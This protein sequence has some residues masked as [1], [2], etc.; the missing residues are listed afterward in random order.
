M[1]SGIITRCG[2][3][4]LFRCVPL[5]LVLS[6]GLHGT[7]SKIIGNDVAEDVDQ[8]FLHPIN[9]F[10]WNEADLEIVD[11]DFVDNNLDYLGSYDDS[12]EERTKKEAQTPVCI[13]SRCLDLYT[14]RS[15]PVVHQQSPMSVT[16][17]NVQ[18]QMQPQSQADPRFSANAM[19]QRSQSGYRNPGIEELHPKPAFPES[20]SV[21]DGEE[22]R[23]ILPHHKQQAP[24]SIP[25][26]KPHPVPHQPHP[27]HSLPIPQPQ[28]NVPFNYNPQPQNY[29]TNVPPS[30][31]NSQPSHQHGNSA[32]SVYPPPPQK[33]PNYESY[34]QHAAQYPTQSATYPQIPINQNTPQYPRPPPPHPQQFYAPPVNYKI[35]TQYSQPPATYPTAHSQHQATSSANAKR[36]DLPQSPPTIPQHSPAH[37]PTPTQ[38]HSQH[39][40]QPH[41]VIQS[42]PTNY[43]LPPQQSNKDPHPEPTQYAPP[44]ASNQHAQPPSN[45]HH[46]QSSHSSPQHSPSPNHVPQHVTPPSSSHAG[47][48][49]H[50]PSGHPSFAQPADE[51]SFHPRIPS[52]SPNSHP[53][54]NNLHSTS[55]NGNAAKAPPQPNPAKQSAPLSPKEMSPV[56]NTIPA[57]EG[58]A[59]DSPTNGPSNNHK[60]ENKD[61]EDPIIASAKGPLNFFESIQPV[62]INEQQERSN[63]QQPMHV[64]LLPTQERHDPF[65][66]SDQS[67]ISDPSARFHSPN[68]GLAGPYNEAVSPDHWRHAPPPPLNYY[69]QDQQIQSYQ[70]PPYCDCG[71]TFNFYQG[72]ANQPPPA[73]YQQPE[74]LTPPSI[75]YQQIPNILP[76]TQ[77]YQ[78]P[79]APTQYQPQPPPPP[80]TQQFYPTIPCPQN[81]LY[82]CAP[83]V[84]E[85]PCEGGYYGGS[86]PSYY[87]VPPPPPPMQ[88]Y[89][90]QTPTNPYRQRFSAT[91]VPA[92]P[93][94]ESNPQ[95]PLRPAEEVINQDERIGQ[96][97]RENAKMAP[98]EEEANVIPAIVQEV[99]TTTTTTSTSTTTT[100]A[101]A[102]VPDNRLLIP[103]APF[104]MGWKTNPVKVDIGDGT[105]ER[106]S[107]GLSLLDDLREK[108]NLGPK[109]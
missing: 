44:T 14:G 56:L 31:Y 42:G 9:A 53:N 25:I 68:V 73:A 30:H 78:H 35:D 55:D 77:Y 13:Q 21:I 59:K 49:S 23:I 10:E 89:P 81:L 5:I 92:D 2:S 87:E 46:Q 6:A 38:T 69:S 7:H 83:T 20:P 61:S 107:S 84:Q 101:P 52:P 43:F 3:I 108:L 105:G 67:G 75:Q 45:V 36:V 24:P 76:P 11:P 91:D 47:P 62:E 98:D 19:I 72:P 95:T 15:V 16:V 33:R 39:N 104:G 57:P 66:R 63:D 41:Q 102:P 28:P 48:Q 1:E 27:Q 71:N 8:D 37:Q 26:Q 103:G 58:A 70:T 17:V 29:Q 85:F 51:H 90:R 4:S 40:A 94:A 82:N 22:G 93:R 80:A 99:T 64:E 106:K 65:Y 79:V 54:S 86:S 97:Q 50:N 32:S 96:E 34:N 12:H 100:P 88:N 109:L 74:I 18:P 60:G